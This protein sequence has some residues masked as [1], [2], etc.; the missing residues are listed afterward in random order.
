VV[1]L[2]ERRAAVVAAAYLLGSVAAGVAAAVLGH[3]LG[4]TVAG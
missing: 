3:L 2:T 1:S 4:R